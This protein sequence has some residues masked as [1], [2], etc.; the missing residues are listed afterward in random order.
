[1]LEEAL[2]RHTRCLHN[3]TMRMWNKAWSA[4]SITAG[5]FLACVISSWDLLYA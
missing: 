3:G 1:V 5:E 2:G 4:A